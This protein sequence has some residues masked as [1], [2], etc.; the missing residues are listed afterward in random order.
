MQPY[1][2]TLNG[3][4]FAI[5]GLYDYYELTKSDTVKDILRA[6]LTTIKYNIYD[7]RVEDDISYYCLRHNI[8]DP[9]YH[10][11]HIA[12]LKYLTNITGDSY[13]SAI[14]EIL[15]NDYWEY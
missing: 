4:M 13:F 8:Q 6:T 11:I 14:G 1:D 15:K 3:F 5:F 2:H 9:F 12:Q 7:Y 10:K